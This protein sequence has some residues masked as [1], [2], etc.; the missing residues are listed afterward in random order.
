ME[1]L[2]LSNLCPRRS[3]L[4][5]SVAAASAVSP[6][7]LPGPNSPAGAATVIGWALDDD[8]D[9]DD[10]AEDAEPKASMPKPLAASSATNV[11]GSSLASLA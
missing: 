11:D 7:L 4:P 1:N 2:P 3:G 10:E 8:D 5:G 6:E 9:D